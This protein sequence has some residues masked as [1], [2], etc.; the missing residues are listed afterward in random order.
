MPKFDKL[1]DSLLS[2]TESI[3]RDVRAGLLEPAA[4]KILQYQDPTTCILVFHEACKHLNREES[5]KLA[6]FL[7]LNR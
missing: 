6:D 1:I 3:A 5:D 7:F 2:Q 4:H